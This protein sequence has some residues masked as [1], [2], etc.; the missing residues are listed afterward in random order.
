MKG[1]ALDL[2]VDLHSY[3][4]LQPRTLGHDQKNKI[5]DTSSWNKFSRQGA[6]CSLRDR[7]RISVAIERSQQRWLGHLF[8]IPPG[9]LPGVVFQV[10]THWRAYV[11]GLAWEC[12]GIPLGELKEVSGESR[13]WMDG[14]KEKPNYETHSLF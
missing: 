6:R 7:V 1:E 3:S 12:F 2:R 5:P 11:S 10:L 13:R 9:S 14:I 8:L 4:C